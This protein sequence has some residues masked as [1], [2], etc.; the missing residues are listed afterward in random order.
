MIDVPTR[1]LRERS[2]ALLREGL[3]EFVADGEA[4][5]LRDRRD[6]MWGM[7]PFHDCARRLGLDPA[8]VFDTA[9]AAG[10]ASLADDVREFGRR[11]DV[12]GSSFG[13]E[14]YDT[15][16]GPAYRFMQP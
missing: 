1:A 11:T 13:Y 8:E 10:P 6:L 4:E 14:L 5:W 9:A 15:P 12:D 2:E 16:D 3:L 7:A